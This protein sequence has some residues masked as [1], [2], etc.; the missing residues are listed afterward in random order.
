MAVFPDLPING[1]FIDYALYP[2]TTT[3]GIFWSFIFLALYVIFLVRATGQA[4]GKVAFAVT[5]LVFSFLAVPLASWGAVGVIIPIITIIA[6]VVS[7]VWLWLSE[8]ITF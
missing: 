7:V 4:K 5:N 2:N 6:T 8:E 1:T 3:D